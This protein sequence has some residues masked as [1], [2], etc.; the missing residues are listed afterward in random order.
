M[1]IKDL[2]PAI[3]IHP[4]E[5][6]QDELGERNIK[7][8]DFA[9]M[10]GMAN[11]QL[12]EIIK[13]KR[14]LNAELALLIGK[15]LGMD[16]AIW[17]NL[18]TNFD[19]DAAKLEG[20]NREKMEAIDTWQMI[21]PVIPSIFFKKE[22][23]ITGNPIIDLPKIKEVY[24][25]NHFDEIAKKFS[26]PTYAHYRKSEKLKIDRVALVGWVN[27]TQYRA[28]NLNVASFDSQKK[29]EL[30]GELK[31]IVLA[32]TKTVEQAMQLLAKYGIK[33]IVQ[34]HPDKCAVDGISFWSKGKPAIG[35]TL[36]HQR[37]DNFAFTLM[38]ELGH[39]Y[40]HLVNNNEA[41]FID[42]ENNYGDSVEEKEANDFARNALISKADWE[43]FQM[44][45]LRPDEK[46]I[47]DFARKKNLH[48]AIVLGRY[49]FERDRF[50][51]KMGIDKKLN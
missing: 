25:V 50:N 13:G 43:E 7:Q 24:Q 45:Y 31:K 22:N 30:I 12:N 42:I 11:T 15:A 2:T 20:K 48:P 16:A 17:M 37:I 46:D 10:I 44:N 39:V 23:I 40:K 6:L 3:A 26:Q 28:N 14:N 5:L 36:R 32:N 9:A 51:F 8:K 49:C 18:Q 21:E 41:Q 38:H 19:L 47:T 27:L 29:D 1:N 33:L 35:M 4:G 34:N